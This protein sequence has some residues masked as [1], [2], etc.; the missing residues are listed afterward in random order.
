M[1]D[2]V[3]VDTNVILDV[4]ANDPVWRQW[5]EEHLAKLVG[6][7]VVNP[8]VYTELCHSATKIEVVESALTSLGLVYLELPREALFLASKA[9]RDY[10]KK[11]GTKTAP[12]ADFFIGAHAAVEGF[13]LL[14]RDVNR[15]RTYF[16]GVKLIHP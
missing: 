9:F 1:T 8:L 3:L 13:K 7:L 4:T 10:R 12:L 16:P 5:S 2:P 6:R 11:G 15:Y 14:T